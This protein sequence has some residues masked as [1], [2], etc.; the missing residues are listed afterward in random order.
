MRIF[1][2]HIFGLFG[3]VLG[4]GQFSDVQFRV[5]D[6]DDGISHRNV[7]KIQQDKNGFIWAATINGLSRFDGYQFLN[8]DSTQSAHYIPNIYIS[9]MIIDEDNY[10]WLA[11]PDYVIGFDPVENKANAIKVK[12]G[13]I[14]RRESRV[15]YNLFVDD[16]KRVWSATFDEKSAV[17]SIQLIENKNT[18]KDL[19]DL[20]GTYTKRP[21][22][23][24]NDSFFI[25][26]YQDELWELDREGTLVDKIVLSESSNLKD[27]GR[28]VQLQLLGDE[29]WILLSDGQ[30]AVFDPFTREVKGHSINS[31]TIGTGVMSSLLVEENGDVWMGG[32]GILWYYSTVNGTVVNYDPPISQIIKNTCYYRQ[33]FRDNSGVVW[34]ATDFGLIKINQSRN[35]FTNYLN[36]GS[37]YCSNVFC[38]T[39]G[40]TEDE[41]GNIYISYYNSIHVFDPKTDAL[42]LLFPNNDYFNYPFGLIY[43]KNFLY[44]GNGR[45]INLENLEVDT[46]FEK[47][48]VDLGAVMKDDDG[49]LWFGYLDN[50]FLYDPATEELSEYTDK[51]GG[52]GSEYGTISYLYQGKSGK[53]IWV[54]TLENGVFKID[55]RR[56]RLT[57]YHAGK[58]SPVR[59]Y[60]NQVNC[61][62][63]D[64]TG[65]IWLAT[66]KG[67]H[68]ID[69]VNN[70]VAVY[71]ADESGLPNDF[72]NGF[73]SEG[74]SC[75]WV[76]TDNGLCRFSME[77]ARCNNFFVSDGLSS[78]EFNRISFYKA[79]DGRMYFGGLN[80]VNAFYPGDQ[81]LE[82]Q[83]AANPEPLFFT[84]FTFFD[85]AEDSLNVIDGGLLSGDKVVLS[86]NDKVFTIS[87]ALANYQQPLENEFSYKLEGYE[88]EWSVPSSINSVRYNNIP[89]G[90]YTFRLRA[91]SG[92]KQWKEEQVFLRI[93]VRE[94]FYNTWW[95][96]GLCAAL[97]LG[98]VWSSA[99][100]RIYLLQKREKQ[101]EHLV[102]KRTKELA[103][104]KEK[105]EALLLNILPAE[106][107]EE[108]KSNGFAKAKRHELVTVMFSDFKGF[109]KI[110]EQ[111]EP[112]A[113]VAEI[114]WCF[115]AFDKIVG[116]HHLEKIKTVGDAYLC[117]SGITGEREDDAIRVVRAAL[118]IQAFMQKTA[119]EKKK[120]GKPYFE[121]RIGI[122]TGP[123]VAGIVGIKKFAYDI[124]GDTVN[125]AARMETNSEVGNVN[126]SEETFQLVKS[127][128]HCIPHGIYNE[129]ERRPIAMYFVKEE[130][131]KQFERA[132]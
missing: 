72:I 127:H 103:Q 14:V 23:Q 119:E 20:N 58:R 34:L 69:P 79:S 22:L 81:F 76:S 132:T 112:E 26:A 86:H 53:Y 71:T 74:D 21:I 50:L 16:D 27:G 88:T 62:Y 75:L 110:S 30:V 66:G 3:V 99:R 64:D 31:T 8:Y 41:A 18:F 115:R 96:W 2:T 12:D 46:L 126:I 13:P 7:F 113:L 38:S 52:W 44:T 90:E 47:P 68:R 101:L 6:F 73:L 118:E 104:E 77:K 93:R 121:A 59:L 17:T 28:I 19:H 45:R 48:N 29:I 9:D 124:W 111:M 84:A 54:A 97:L 92:N 1:L 5:Y 91:R 105:S 109:T 55:K 49:I 35:L 24:W 106:I 15:P 40:I 107:A 78:N 102:K 32:R 39:R 36:G 116:K 57:H 94:A 131:G 98:A 117:V 130:I 60:H 56:G 114:D 120:L 95:F 61:V 25:G 43:D 83:T 100:Y 125:I 11:S 33:I 85:G 63:E 87:Y 65:L 42:R 10:I 89:A 51:E 122:H 128:Y 129:I 108:L 70:N 123:L 37:E 67:I 4:F 82:D 80:G